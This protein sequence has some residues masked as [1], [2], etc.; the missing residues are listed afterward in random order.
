MRQGFIIAAIVLWV[1]INYLGSIAEMQPLLGQIDTKTGLTQQQT[2]EEMRKPEITDVNIITI[3][4]K[5]G[6]YAILLGKILTLWH[7]AIWQGSAMYLYFLLIL[8]IG[9]SFWIILLMALRGV[10]SS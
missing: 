9:I 8:P 1:A 6:H 5:I 7:P 10:G 3:F 4:S 2:L